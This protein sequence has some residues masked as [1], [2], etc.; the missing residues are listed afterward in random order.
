MALQFN[1]AEIPT[2]GDVTFNGT[3]FRE[4]RYKTNN[5]H[6]IVR[7]LNNYSEK[8]ALYP[9]ELTKIIRHNHLTQYDKQTK[10]TK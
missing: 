10:A 4:V 7:Y 1:G 3:S 6:P 8:K 9:I 2:S 5:P